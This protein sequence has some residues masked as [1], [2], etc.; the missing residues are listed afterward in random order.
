[1]KENVLVRLMFVFAF[2]LF[3]AVPGLSRAATY[4]IIDLGVDGRSAAGVALS[5]YGHALIGLDLAFIGDQPPILFN[6][7]NSTTNVQPSFPN[8]AVLTD[9]GELF[10]TV[11]VEG[12]TVI[13]RFNNGAIQDVGQMPHSS[14]SFIGVNQSLQYFAV[15]DLS[16]TPFSITGRIGSDA[17]VDLGGLGGDLTIALDIN[18][19]GSIVGISRTGDSASSGNTFE[20]AFVYEEGAMRGLGTLGGISSMA[21]AINN[22]GTVIGE[23]QV[24]TSG[25]VHAFIY[26]PVNGMRG[27]GLP[28]LDSVATDVN[29]LGVIVGSAER[30]PDVW[31][32]ALLSETGGVQYLED[33]IPANSGWTSLFRATDINN[34]G[35][36]AGI[37]MINGVMHAF[38]MMPIPE[39]SSFVLTIFALAWINPQRRHKL[40]FAR[41]H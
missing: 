9:T 16:S 40:D 36:I 28:D 32:A 13:R 39:P 29:D 2:F 41:S 37:G 1:M 7:A 19:T 35:Q 6:D 22:A 25:P 23:S 34:H 27:I 11:S 3:S 31:Q 38:L 15:V 17:V 26:D 10:G 18:Q 24:T 4:S 21:R 30:W 14:V 8:G 20:E 5:D 12:E 33:I